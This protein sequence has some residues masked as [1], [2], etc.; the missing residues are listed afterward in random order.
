M[1]LDDRNPRFIIASV[2][3]GD[4]GEFAH[5]LIDQNSKV[6][7][8]SRFSD[9]IVLVTAAAD[10]TLYLVSHKDAPRGKILRL[11]AGDTNLAHATVLV[12]QSE[13]VIQGGGEFGG[14]PVIVTSHSIY[15]R[16]VIGGPSRVAIF[17]MSGHPKGT[18][19]LPDPAAVT[20]VIPLDDD[21]IAYSVETYTRPRYFARYMAKTG[22]AV[23]TSSPRPAP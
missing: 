17:D 8:I 6:T 16:E 13:A 20:E 4:G 1:L 5:Y 18:L 23:D 21:S 12:P 10:G 7:P 9:K 3:N 11:A 14:A 15:V 22:H 2:A 19:P